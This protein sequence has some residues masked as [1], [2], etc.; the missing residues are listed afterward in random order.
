MKRFVLKACVAAVAA[1]GT[2]QMAPLAAPVPSVRAA[3]LEVQASVDRRRV[4]VGETIMLSVDVIGTQKA[5]RPKLDKLDGFEVAYLGATQ[6]FS[7]VNGT[8]S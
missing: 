1:L 4:R 8:V 5:R 6:K 2:M 7:M 3:E